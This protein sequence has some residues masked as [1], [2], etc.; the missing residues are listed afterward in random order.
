MNILEK[1]VEGAAS[2]KATRREQLVPQGFDS[3]KASVARRSE[4]HSRNRVPEG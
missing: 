2:T 3:K 1:S 4:G